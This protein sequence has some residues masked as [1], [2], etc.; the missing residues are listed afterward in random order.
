MAAR[1]RARSPFEQAQ[2]N[3]TRSARR[4]T[5]LPGRTETAT[6]GRMDGQSYGCKVQQVKENVGRP[7]P[8]DWIPATS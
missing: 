2:M 6:G 4:D 7:I 3:T 5:D 8:P 1:S